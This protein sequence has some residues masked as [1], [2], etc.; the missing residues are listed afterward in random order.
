[1][2]T[3]PHTVAKIKCSL[4][5]KQISSKHIKQHIRKQHQVGTKRKYNVSFQGQLIDPIKDYQIEHKLRK[6]V[7]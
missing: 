6:K 7:E 5:Q 3:R 1:M 4:C 2:H